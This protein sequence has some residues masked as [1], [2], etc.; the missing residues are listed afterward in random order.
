MGQPYTGRFAP[1]PS[2]PLHFGSLVAALASYL[3]A[4]AHDGLW[5][6]RMED[7]DPA[8]EPP[9]AAS[10]ILHA[11]E[12]FGLHW[13]GSVL[14]QSQRLDVYAEAFANL[15]ARGLIYACDC[16]RQLIHSLGGVYDNRC[17]SREPALT[18]GAWRLKVAGNIR[19]ADAVQGD[20]EQDLLQSCG[21]FTLLRKDGLFAYQLAVV[22]DDGYQHI[23]D[24]VRGWDLLEST[25]RQIYLQRLL[26]LATPR[27]AHV[28]IAINREG[29]KLSKQHFAAPLPTDRPAR[30]LTHALRFLGQQPEPG[31]ERASITEVLSW[32]TQ[33]W[34]IQAVPKLAT[35]VS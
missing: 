14:Y 15:R 4:R 8:R 34:D 32:A 30:E 2:G 1:S 24:V 17:R 9:E 7:L 31:L 5:L 13:D 22:V 35:I 18:K 10:Q 28:P 27:Y 21:D 11:L 6:L 16:S 26:G 33:R 25:A 3:D 29:Q 23:T 12:R 19:F 20:Q